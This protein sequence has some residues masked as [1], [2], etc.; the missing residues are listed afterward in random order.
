MR[1]EKDKRIGETIKVNIFVHLAC[2]AIALGLAARYAFGGT[3]RYPLAAVCIACGAYMVVCLFRFVRFLKAWENTFLQIDGERIRGYSV[4][5]RRGTGAAF[6]IG[7]GEVEDVS[8]QELKLTN[9]TPLPVLVIRTPS[10]PHTV[11]G[12]EEMQTAR[13]KL[14]P[15]NTIF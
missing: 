4:D 12:I 10:G 6:E 13:S 15:E 9:R 1:F 3:P 14:L 5:A 7:R 2:I 11:L 8:V